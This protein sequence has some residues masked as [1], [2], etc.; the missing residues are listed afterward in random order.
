M[1]KKS[2]VWNLQQVRDKS[3]QSAW[4]YDTSSY[5]LWAW[6]KNAKGGLGQTDA[7]GVA[8]DSPVQI[9]GSWS[10]MA[11]QTYNNEYHLAIKPDGT[12]WGWG[13]N[14]HGQLGLSNK[15]YYSSPVQIPGTTWAAV[16]TAYRCTMATKTDGTLWTWGNNDQGQLGHNNKNPT[17]YSSP[18]QIPGTTWPT[19][20]NKMSGATYGMYAIKTDGTLWMWGYNAMGQLGQN[21]KTN[22]SSP[23]QVPGSWSYLSNASHSTHTM[24]AIRTDGTLWSWGINQEGVLG[25]NQ[26]TGTAYSSPVQ[27]GTETTWTGIGSG[28]KSIFGTK[29]DNTFWSWGYNAYGQLGQNNKT[30]Y[31]SPTQ[32]P[33]TTWSAGGSSGSRSTTTLFS[34]TDG[35]LWSV[36]WGA[37]WGMLGAGIGASVKRS[38]PVQIGSETDWASGYGSVSMNYGN[39]YA[40]RSL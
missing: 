24:S 16:A 22:Y 8:K 7:L 6:G 15:T 23:V 13:E 30:R 14:Q 21:N 3:L 31:S 1:A 2:G 33:G 20:N 29:S 17:S 40:L 10:K 5:S 36:G 9:P 35:T 18:K 38:S 11:H 39:G 4:D 12:M 26:P 25:L 27:V 34:K 28:N 19:D 32:I 37:D